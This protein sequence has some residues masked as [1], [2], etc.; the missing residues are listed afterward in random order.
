MRIRDDL[1]ARVDA[2]TGL[3]GARSIHVALEQWL[4]VG[5]LPECLAGLVAA[6]EELRKEVAQLRADVARLQEGER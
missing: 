5:L 6:V 1:R 4:A 2:S 3:Q